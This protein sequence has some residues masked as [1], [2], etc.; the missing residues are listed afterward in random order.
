M[1]S[2]NEIEYKINKEINFL[3]GNILPSPYRQNDPIKCNDCIFRQI[4]ILIVSGKIKVRKIICDSNK[5]WRQN[6]DIKPSTAGKRHGAIW[7]DSTI[8]T[9][10]DYFKLNN[11]TT[12]LEPNLHYGRA[13]IGITSLNLFIEV[14]TIN[15]YKLYCNLINMTDCKIIVVSENNNFIEF[16]L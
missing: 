8:K 13:D 7:H 14:G 12:Q 10:E 11:Y 9:I 5:I 16:N 4:A 15:L 2:W 6:G 1:P 3:E